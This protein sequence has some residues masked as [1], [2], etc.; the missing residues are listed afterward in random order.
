[1]VQ[2]GAPESVVTTQTGS[3]TESSSPALAPPPDLV[4]NNLLNQHHAYAQAIEQAVPVPAPPPPEPGLCLFAEAGFWMVHSYFGTNPTFRFVART[5][6]PA[7][8]PIEG[9]SFDYSV[10]FG[11]RVTVG[12]AGPDG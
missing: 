9:H 10:D 5:R 3:T 4:W 2:G 11:P 1:L 12:A 8:P 7:S 6:P